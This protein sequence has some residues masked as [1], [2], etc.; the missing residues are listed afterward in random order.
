MQY[1]DTILF[2]FYLVCFRIEF[3][4]IFVKLNSFQGRHCG[5]VGPDIAWDGCTHVGGL[6]LSHS[7]ASDGA[8]CK[9]TWEEAGDD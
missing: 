8:S 6:G 1:F 3:F 4:L 7:A 2:T 9:C 5:I